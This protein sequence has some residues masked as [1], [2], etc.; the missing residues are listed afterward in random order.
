MQSI[1]FCGPV[2]HQWEGY[3][4]YLSHPG[5]RG[6]KLVDGEWVEM[7]SDEA[8]RVLHEHFK[9]YLLTHKPCGCWEAESKRQDQVCLKAG[10][11]HQVRDRSLVPEEHR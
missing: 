5:I 7:S 1:L 4:A 3:R 6:Q 9:P 10:V 2:M 11:W 8:G